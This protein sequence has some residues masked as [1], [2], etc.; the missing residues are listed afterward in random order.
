MSF[1]LRTAL[2]NGL[3]QDELVEAITHQAFYAG[4]RSAVGAI[5]A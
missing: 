3:T 1:H 4:W 5:G 2:D